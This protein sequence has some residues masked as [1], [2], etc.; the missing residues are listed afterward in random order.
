MGEYLPI[1]I[2][3]A[4]IGAFAVAFVAAYLGVKNRKEAMGFDR[5][6]PDGEIIRR[7]MKYVRPHWKEFLIAFVI[8]AVS[9]LYDLVAPLIV[10]RIQ[11]IIKDRFELSVLFRWVAVYAGILVVSMMMQRI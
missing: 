10:G 5:H 11:G 7:L 6:I 2:V 1:L 8:M 4:I 3:A 9:I